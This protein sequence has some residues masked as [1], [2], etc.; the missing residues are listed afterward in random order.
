MGTDG[1][2]MRE[3]LG[4]SLTE[5]IASYRKTIAEVDAIGRRIETYRMIDSLLDSG[6]PSDLLVANSRLISI[7]EAMAEEANSHLHELLPRQLFRLYEKYR[8]TVD[9]IFPQS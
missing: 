5:C 3:G 9:T 2:C 6:R 8:A 4:R 1:L 7:V